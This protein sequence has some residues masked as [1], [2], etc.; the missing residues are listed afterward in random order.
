MYLWGELMKKRKMRIICLAIA[1]CAIAATLIIRPL[2]DDP[3][4]ASSSP[5]YLNEIC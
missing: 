2:Q 4:S 1:F 5:S 3:P